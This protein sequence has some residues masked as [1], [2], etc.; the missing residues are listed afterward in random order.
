MISLRRPFLAVSFVAWVCTA[1]VAVF[2]QALEG[3]QRCTAL[4]RSGFGT[5]SDAPTRLRAAAVRG[6]GEARRCIIEGV[7]APE[8]GFEL[9]L[10]VAD[11]WNGKFVMLGCGGFCGSIREVYDVCDAVNGR[12]YACILTDMGHRGTPFQGGWA[13]N[14][15]AAEVDFGFRATHVVAKAGKAIAAEY[16]GRAPARSYFL[17]CSTG[18]RQGLVSAQRFPADFDGIVAGAPII[19]LTGATMQIVWNVRATIDARRNALLPAEAV[20]R[21]HREVMKQCDA[22]D[23]L[24]DGILEDPRRCALDI[25]AA[26][27]T[28]QAKSACLDPAARAAAEKLYS[29][30]RNAKGERVGLAGLVPGS[31][32]AWIGPFV[33]RIGGAGE[34]FPLAAENYRYMGF[35]PDPGPNWQPEDFD[36]DR[37]PDRLGLMEALLGGM[38]P[39]LRRFRARGGKLI[40]FQ[41]WNDVF[42][43]P[44]NIIDYAAMVTGA[45]GGRAATDTFFRLFM[46]PGMEHCGGG[47][48]AGAIDWLTALEEWVENDRPPERLRGARLSVRGDILGIAPIDPQAIEMT[49]PV[50]PYPAQARYRGTGD[51]NDAA[52]FERVEP[53]P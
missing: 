27:C 30:A 46:I 7:V 21:L 32:K 1:S 8:V 10:P 34:A 13:Y 52:N 5:L 38:N 23:G 14:N 6:E 47:N 53:V 48:G 39:D 19:D 2:A 26:A 24:T 35:F 42:V 11:A 3:D 45:M 22:A 31:E 43:P 36:F 28:G 16:Y 41:G 49:R 25:A 12:G 50:F 9:R 37:D 18:G 44:L 15:L 17:G 40:V 33:S 29:G 20:E 4:L 51:P